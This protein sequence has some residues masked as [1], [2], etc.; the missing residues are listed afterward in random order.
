M[1]AVF[2]FFCFLVL[3]V[4]LPSVLSAATPVKLAQ[5]RELRKRPQAGGIPTNRCKFMTAAIKISGHDAQTELPT[6]G[7][8]AGGCAGCRW[9]ISVLRAVGNGINRPALERYIEGISAKVLSDRLK[10]HPLR[11]F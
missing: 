4:T 3:V 8:A 9:T 1:M 11:G 2:I 10:N 7:C 5:L 6:G